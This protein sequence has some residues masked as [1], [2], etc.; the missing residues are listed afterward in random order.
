MFFSVNVLNET[1][2][3]RLWKILKSGMKEKLGGEEKV[4]E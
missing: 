1:F 3:K 4:S 2:K